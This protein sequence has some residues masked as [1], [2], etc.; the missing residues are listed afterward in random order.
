MTAPEAGLRTPSLRRRLTVVVVAMVAV[1]LVVLVLATDVALRERLDGQL[2]DRLLDRA[3][4]AEALADQVDERDLARRLEGDGISVVLVTADGA[5][6]AEGPLAGGAVTSDD[7]AGPSE[8]PQPPAPGPGP[9]PGGPPGTDAVDRDG[10]RLTVVRNLPGGDRVLLLAD[11]G[12]VRETVTQVRLVL[13]LA[14]AAVLLLTAALVPLVVR[15]SL[16]P[17]G[18]ITDVAREITRGDRAKRLRPVSPGTDLGRTAEAFDEMLDA[19]VG[20]EERAR[21]SEGRLRAFL[22]DAAHELRTPVAAVQASAENLLREDPPRAEREEVLVGLIRQTRTAGRLVDD[23]VLMARI[24]EGLPLELAPT[25]LRAVVDDVLAA[26]ADLHPDARLEATGHAAPV[27]ADRD[28]VAQVLTNLVTNAVRAGGPSTA[29]RVVLADDPGS[30]SAVVEV[31]DDGPGVPAE[32]RER[33]FARLVRLEDS[34]ARYPGS[35]LGLPIARGIAE[36][37]GGTLA[38]LPPRD[39]DG[40]RG[41]RFRLSLPRTAVVEPGAAHP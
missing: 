37:H 34:R 6:Y 8:G 7:P 38:C 3:E 39:E 22:S 5:T 12:S 28:R 30:G 17:L 35:G 18:R 16:A 26:L 10:D 1:V 25:D 24:D 27:T 33:V 2:R 11:A 19:V 40:G 14:A 9:P 41:A 36:R 4:V 31:L 21:G 15:R 29:V 32:Q 20:A 23:L 13:L